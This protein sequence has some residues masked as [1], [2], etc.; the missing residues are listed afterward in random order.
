[1]DKVYLVWQGEYSDSRVIAVFDNLRD[2]EVHAAKVD[3]NCQIE[4]RVVNEIKINYD[5]DTTVGY[6]ITACYYDGEFSWISVDSYCSA[7]IGKNRPVRN[8]VNEIKRYGPHAAYYKV[9]VVANSKDKALKIASD[10][11]AKYRAEKAGL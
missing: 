5:N 10:L 2:A 1:M 8:K 11:I 3:D 6:N 9:M 7:K 4:E